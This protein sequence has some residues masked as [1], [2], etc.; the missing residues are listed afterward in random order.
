MLDFKTLNFLFGR[1]ISSLPDFPDVKES[2]YDGLYFDS[3][4]RGTLVTGNPGT[5]KTTW[6]AGILIEYALEKPDRPVI[7]LDASGSLTNEFLEIWM[8]LGR[9]DHEKIGKRIV[10]DKPGHPT[11]VLPKP[12]F[13]SSYGLSDEELVQKVTMIIEQLNTELL[14]QTPVMA[15][16]ITNTAPNI[17]RLVQALK[18]EY[19]ESWQITE[20]NSLLEDTFEGGQLDIACRKVETELP[21]VAKHF[22]RSLLKE[23]LSAAGRESRTFALTSALGVIDTKPLRA[24]YGYY[25]PGVTI[26]EIIRKGLIYF[27]DGSELTNQKKAQAFVFWDEYASLKAL[28]NKRIPHDKRNKPVLLVIDEVYQLF[29]FKGLSEEIGQI[30]AYYR[31]RRLCPI[32]V[33][34]AFWQLDELLKEQIWNMGNLVTFALDNHSDAYKFAQQTIPYDPLE[35]K[36]ENDKGMDQLEPDR[37]QYLKESNWLQRLGW[38]Q[39][40]MRRYLNERDKEGFVAFIEK[41]REKPQSTLAEG[42]LDTIKEELF[43]RRAIEIRQA[44]DVI[45][46]RELVEEKTRKGVKKDGA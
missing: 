8:S 15:K 2:D 19:G 11:K 41:T 23:Q 44:L 45:D 16:A 35:I 37:G 43:D 21:T 34:Q 24:R 39:L 4:T 18:N 6:L 29:K 46:R 36:L 7:V 13:H 32:F 42:Q 27:I 26:E 9:D 33:I 40:A 25:R 38:R 28:I 22:R 5:G 10:Y 1:K 30:S 12:I 3:L 17:F 20:V 14:E 31:S